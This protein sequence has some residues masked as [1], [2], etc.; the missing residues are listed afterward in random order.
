MLKGSLR[1]VEFEVKPIAVSNG[2]PLLPRS[3]SPTR[4]C[5]LQRHVRLCGFAQLAA[6][7]VRRLRRAFRCAAIR[8]TRLG[9]L[10]WQLRWRCGPLL[11]RAAFWHPLAGVLSTACTRGP[12]RSPA[13]GSSLRLD[14]TIP[15]LPARNS[16]CRGFRL[17]NV[18]AVLVNLPC[19]QFCRR[20]PVVVYRG[21]GWLCLWPILRKAHERRLFGHWL[22]DAGCVPRPLLDF[23]QKA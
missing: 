19:A 8:H 21:L 7:T 20:G 6:C 5:S 3:H 11:D 15:P 14:D 22:G 13:D 10:V 2:P 12:D 16:R 23:E 4:R 1:E 18:A 9:L 17:R